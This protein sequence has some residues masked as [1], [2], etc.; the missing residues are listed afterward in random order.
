MCSSDLERVRGARAEAHQ[1]LGARFARAGERTLAA[2]AESL[3]RQ[4]Q[5]LANLNPQRVLER[6][7]ALLEAVDGHALVSAAALAPGMPVR[8]VLH[9]GRADMQVQRVAPAREGDAPA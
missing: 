1:S 3:R 4:G 8:A 2:R 9:D 5:A 6:G 7:Y